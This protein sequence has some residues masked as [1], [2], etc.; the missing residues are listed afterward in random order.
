M[1]VLSLA[2]GCAVSLLS[3]SA[4]AFVPTSLKSSGRLERLRPRAEANDASE[5]FDGPADLMEVRKSNPAVAPVAALAA[6]ASSPLA[7]QAKIIFSDDAYD[8]TKTDR[9]AGVYHFP[10]GLG[11]VKFIWAN[12]EPIPTSE[13]ILPSEML[14]VAAGVIFWTI[15]GVALGSLALPIVNG[16]FKGVEEKK[17][18][19]FLKRFE[20]SESEEK[21]LEELFEIAEAY[22]PVGL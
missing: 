10:L 5:S 4:D 20:V 21:A 2:A 9:T 17:R 19:D 11:E 22:A 6:L 8:Y 18:K 12:T 3:F 7:A 15:F 1:K 16:Y 13:P 14:D